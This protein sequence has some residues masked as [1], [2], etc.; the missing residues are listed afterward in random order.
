MPVTT[1]SYRSLFANRGYRW[2]WLGLT[3]NFLG[4]QVGQLGLSWF[5]KL[6]SDSPSAVG[7]ALSLGTAFTAV[8]ALLVGPLLDRGSR[9]RLMI[10][11]NLGRGLIALLLPLLFVQG[12]LHLWQ[13]FVAMAVMGLLGAFTKVGQSAITPALVTEP[14]L[15]AS[16]NALNQV[17]WQVAY[18]A[19]P[20]LGGLLLEWFH[21]MTVLMVDGLTF[22]FFALALTQ[23]PA[24]VDQV[25]RSSA[26]YWRSMREGVGLLLGSRPLVAL[27]LNTFLI[28]TFY[29]PLP[30]A[31]VF[32]VDRQL[33]AGATEL[34]WIWSVFAAGTLTGGLL[35][36]MIGRWPAGRAIA[37]ITFLW[38]ALTAPLVWVHSLPLAL[39]C[40]FLAGVSWAPYNVIEVTARQRAVP[41]DSY[42]RVFGLILVVTQMGVP[43]GSALGGLLVDRVGPGATLALAGAAC[44]L[45]GLVG[46]FSRSLRLLD[47]SAG[48]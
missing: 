3:V 20:A 45:L 23:L 30:V 32:Y 33:G 22:L 31:L 26:T 27:T 47:H 6:E 37:T 28:N 21:P 10:I 29:G 35:S 11:D 24:A 36:G 34:G 9:R 8:G 14:E 48:V 43:L 2:F 46:W 15:L 7:A 4:S 44:M 39:L 38:G 40:M 5:V 12:W 19:G 42:G 16:A 17:Q 25:R 13:I 41:P 1:P 18:L